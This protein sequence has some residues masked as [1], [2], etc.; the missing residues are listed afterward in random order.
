[1]WHNTR[2][3]VQMRHPIVGTQHIGNGGQPLPAR[4]LPPRGPGLPA[5]SGAS[6]GHVA[7]E[8]S[9]PLPPQRT[10]WQI[11]PSGPLAHVRWC[12]DGALAASHGPWGHLRQRI[13]ADRA[14]GRGGGGGPRPLPQCG[15][16]GGRRAARSVEASGRATVDAPGP[17]SRAP[18]ATAGNR[19]HRLVAPPWRTVRAAGDQPP[20]PDRLGP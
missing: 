12:G 14:M 3:P 16:P 17:A 13:H 11:R 15:R 7:R 20:V 2:A 18:L 1:M 5:H 6:S 4:Q 9:R 10:E 19:I 8:P